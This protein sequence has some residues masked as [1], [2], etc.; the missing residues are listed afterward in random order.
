MLVMSMR[1]LKKGAIMATRTR[2]SW[3]FIV[4]FG[5]LTVFSILSMSSV[6]AYETDQLIGI[7]GYVFTPKDMISKTDFEKSNFYGYLRD[8]EDYTRGIY[9][10]FRTK[11]SL[12]GGV[13]I[14]ILWVEPYFDKQ[15][16]KEMPWV[17]GEIRPTK[18]GTGRT[19]NF[20]KYRSTYEGVIPEDFEIVFPM[21]NM[22]ITFDYGKLAF[23]TPAGEISVDIVGKSLAKFSNFWG[24]E[25]EARQ[26]IFVTYAVFSELERSGIVSESDIYVARVVVTVAGGSV[27]SPWN[28]NKIEKNKR[29]IEEKL[30]KYGDTLE[31]NVARPEK[32][33]KE[34]ISDMSLMLISLLLVLILGLIYAFILVSFR[35]FDIATLRAI[36]W[37]SSHIRALTMGEFSLTIIVGYILG[38]VVGGILLTAYKVPITPYSFLIS[39]AIL[40]VSILAG[41]L[42][43]SKRVLGI[44]PM[45]A[46]RA[47]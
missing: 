31:F 35:K 46:F 41:L 27:T 14:G 18:I 23:D 4:L 34:Y 21:E 16:D 13:S 45:E 36:G 9:V 44:P 12:M 19:V 1:A 30:D 47:R 25:S 6:Y 40:L 43:I 26:S 3:V 29:S 32:S 39:L 33:A 10:V 11:I 20:D 24:S 42:L 8:I 22:S 5:I 28:V 2:K 17:I 38:T 7:R 15:Y 37:G